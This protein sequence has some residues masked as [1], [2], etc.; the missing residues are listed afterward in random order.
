LLVSIDAKAFEIVDVCDYEGNISTTP[1]IHSLPRDTRKM[2]RLASKRGFT[3]IEL[4][5]VIAIIAILIGLL[6]PAVQKVREAATRMTCQN[7]MKQ[8]ALAMHNHH[9]AVGRFPAGQEVANLTGSCPAQSDPT[10]DARTPWGVAILPYIEQDNLYHKFVLTGTFAIDREFLSSAN[11]SNRSFQTTVMPIFQCPADPRTV[12]SDRTSYLPVAGGGSPT[13]C[14]CVATKTPT[15]IIY[16]NGTFYINSRTKLTD[17][18]DGT[19]NTYLIGE[20]KYQ[21]AD[22]RPSDGAEKRGLWS[23]GVYL[24][25][26]WKYYSALAAAVEPINQ[27][28]GIADYTATGIRANE[29]IVGRTFGSLHIGGCNMAFGDGSVRFMLNSTD[30]NVHRSLGTIADGLPAGG[31]P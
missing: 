31:A 1:D 19:T 16:T 24:R 7:K 22:I 12:G 6:L 23:G 10:A 2:S 11:A 14:T 9:D 21:V 25:P 5:V 4:L 18:T 13:G 8:I 15:F 30:I 29:A 28:S 17:I 27:P 3:L 20:S 26:D